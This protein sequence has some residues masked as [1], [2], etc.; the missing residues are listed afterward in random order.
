MNV[1]SIEDS[2]N[3]H[4]DDLN[5][6]IQSTKNN[7]SSTTATNRS[8]ANLI[9]STTKQEDDILPHDG[10]A[11]AS[12]TQDGAHDDCNHDYPKHKL[13]HMPLGKFGTENT[14]VEQPI[15]HVAKKY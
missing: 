4:R 2:H 8:L 1:I 11:V 7:L 9:E 13:R 10:S 15:T 12:V 14:N 6:T 3:Q 5:I